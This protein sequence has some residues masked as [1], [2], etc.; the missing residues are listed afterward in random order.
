MSMNA[1]SSLFSSFL[2]QMSGR[3]YHVFRRSFTSE[4]TLKLCIYAFSQDLQSNQGIYNTCKNLSHGAQQG[5]TEV[6]IAIAT[7][8]YSCFIYRVVILAFRKS[9]TFF[10]K[11][12][13]KFI[14]AL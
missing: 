11:D 8:T 4:S 10:L 5:D 1:M 2:L 3:E 6:T 12:A 9:C 14:R 13:K 7:I